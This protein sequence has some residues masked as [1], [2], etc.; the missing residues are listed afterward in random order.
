MGC[1]KMVKYLKQKKKLSIV[2]LGC[3]K[4]LVDSEIMLGLI[5]KDGY[6][7]TENNQDA[8]II[9]VNTCGFIDKSKEDSINTVLEI[10]E[11]KE[12]GH[13]ES[14]IVTG[15]LTQRY[16]EELM[17]E[18]P[19]IDGLVGTGEFN[20]ITEVLIKAL[21][22]KKPIYIGNP[23]YTYEEILPRIRTTPSHYAYIKI[24]EGCD[25][26]CTFWVIPSLRGKCRSRGISSIVNEAKEVVSQGVKE[27]S[28]IAQ[29]TTYYGMDKYGKIMLSELIEELSKIEGLDW[30]RLHYLYPGYMTDDL[31]ESFA[32][33][34]KLCKYIDMPL[35]HSEDHILKKMLRPG[36][37]TDIRELIKKIRSKVPEIALRTSIIVGFPGETEKDFEHLLDFVKEIKFDRLGVFTYSEEE[38]SPAARLPNQVPQDEKERRAEILMEVQREIANEKSAGLIGNIVDVIIERY[39]EENNV[40]AGR[41]QY[42]A[43]EID[44][45]VFVSNVKGIIGD[46]IKVRITHSLD[47]D[48]F[49]EEL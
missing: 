29:D 9:I 38:G 49:G 17:K 2:T 19:E 45:E 16:K 27:I 35:Q 31:I 8:D 47:F 6:E 24:A 43:P 13:L 46:I 26:S 23:V 30:I 10:A 39:D 44:G 42:D 3:E 25:N 28:L 18:I 36:R 22:G 11:Y 7:I 1:R 4:N 12:T 5:D 34:S 20:K 48:L 32:N 40:Y 33:Q 41:T 21:E 14:L 15:C 37:Q